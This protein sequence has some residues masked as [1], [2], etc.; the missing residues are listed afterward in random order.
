[1]PGSVR[2]MQVPSCKEFVQLPRASHRA[3]TGRGLLAAVLLAATAVVAPTDVAAQSLRQTLE[4]AATAEPQLASALLTYYRVRDFAPVWTDPSRQQ[5]LLGAL[6]AL[7]DD[8]LNPQ[9]YALD[10]L[11]H[12]WSSPAAAD[13]T[14]T[15]AVATR[16][17]FTAL[18]H[19]LNGKVDPRALE[20]E[21]NFQPRP[22]DLER[23]LRNAALM[24]DNG[25]IAALFDGARPQHPLYGQLRAGLHQ[26]YRIADHGGWPPI[27]PGETLKP[28]MRDPRVVALRERLRLGGYPAVPAPV[29]LREIPAL[30]E[31]RW[32]GGYPVP[33]VVAGN[34][35]DDDDAHEYVFDSAL[36]TALR[37]FQHEQYL[38]VDGMLGKATL[39]A[40]NLPVHQR[41]AQLRANLERARWLLHEPSREFLLV[42]IAGYKASLFRDGQATWTTRVQVGKPYRETPSFRS[43]IDRI[44]FNPTWTVPPTILRKDILP[45]I[46]ANPGY[47][48]ANRLRVLDANGSE[49]DPQQVDWTNPR[50]I[51][52]R[53]DAGDGAALGQV[54]IR[55]DNPYSV[56]LHDTPH[57]EL[58]GREQRAF[59]S[60]CIRVEQPL[61]LVQRLF[62]DPVQWNRAAIDAAIANHQTRTVR[63]AQPMT[64]L[65][66]YWSVDVHRGGWLSFKPDIYRRDARLLTLLDQ[67]QTLHLDNWK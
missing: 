13:P 4:Q 37:R 49:L 3:S 67:P 27:A 35:D 63:L 6:A 21:W 25:Q 9:D 64:V 59:S 40:L 2:H 55:F 28:G 62:N 45:K 36:E 61:E 39:A 43:R 33:P 5:A 50:G 22:L 52:L 38:D 18:A 66:V 42:D 11:R 16:A 29:R 44:T 32:L 10:T 57:T 51:T 24:I 26:L 7:R 30:R 46:R 41:I 8:G 19:L 56:Y 31:R 34:G 60:G 1:M 12:A 17:L 15:E 53:Q 65:L 54:V 48:A 58:F 23:G 47:L 20:P 14:A